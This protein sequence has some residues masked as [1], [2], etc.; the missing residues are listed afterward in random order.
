MSEGSAQLIL[1]TLRLVQT[2]IKEIH[3][4]INKTNITLTEVHTQVKYTN[5]RVTKIEDGHVN[6]AGK[7]AI[8]QLLEQKGE[9]KVK[10]SKSYQ[11]G[12]FI[13]IAG[14]IGGLILGFLNYMKK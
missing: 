1:E 10:D 8:S 2:D 7:Q 14:F 9:Q 5:G 11:I 4:K 12:A 6:C 13:L 3:E